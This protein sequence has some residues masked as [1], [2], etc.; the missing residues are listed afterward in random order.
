MN[1]TLFSIIVVFF[2]ASLIYM[3]A[4]TYDY[5]RQMPMSMRAQEGRTNAVNVDYG[6]TVFV[7]S[8]EKKKIG[9]AN[10]L[11]GTSGIVLFVSICIHM[12]TKSRKQ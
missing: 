3:A 9:Q 10:I 12:N 8:A 11:F 5:T 1:K 7:T 4:L 6:K 2:I